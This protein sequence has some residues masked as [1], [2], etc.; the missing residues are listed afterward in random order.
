V[1]ATVEANPTAL[2]ARELGVGVVRSGV[3]PHPRREARRLLDNV[4]EISNG[5]KSSWL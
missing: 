1:A 2:N 3:A 5:H 4:Q